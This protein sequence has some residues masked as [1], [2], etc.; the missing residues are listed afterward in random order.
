MEKVLK[1]L[2]DEGLCL[3]FESKELI[4]I[5]FENDPEI[6]N[7]YVLHCLCLT[8]VIRFKK[9]IGFGG[10]FDFYNRDV[11]LKYLKSLEINLFGESLRCRM[12]AKR[13]LCYCGSVDIDKDVVNYFYPG[14]DIVSLFMNETEKKAKKFIILEEAVNKYLKERRI[15]KKLLDAIDLE[16]EDMNQSKLQA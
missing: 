9:L 14:W 12:S 6:T 4:R 2:D 1:V 16:L 15:F 7:R 8:G 5:L 3:S 10:G 11:L 13:L